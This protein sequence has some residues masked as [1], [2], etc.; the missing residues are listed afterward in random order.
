M[1]GIIIIICDIV[2]LH[3]KLGKLRKS[4]MREFKA[5]PNNIMDGAL[6]LIQHS[7]SVSISA[8]LFW[9]TTDP[10]PHSYP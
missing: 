8:K 6:I 1:L 3:I 10:S 2:T 4:C 7:L 5:E 9:S